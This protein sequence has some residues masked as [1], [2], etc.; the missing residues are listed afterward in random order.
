MYIAFYKLACYKLH[1]QQTGE[2]GKPSSRRVRVEGG[3]GLIAMT[4][5]TNTTIII[6]IIII[7]ITITTILIS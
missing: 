2:Q 5:I 1:L 4:I 6:I 3:E 7:I